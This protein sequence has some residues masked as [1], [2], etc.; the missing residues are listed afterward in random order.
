MNMVVIYNKLYYNKFVTSIIILSLTISLVYLRS[1]N[2][3]HTIYKRR[4][5]KPHIVEKN[6]NSGNA[7]K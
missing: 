6:Q 7:F 3:S 5:K 1:F 2:K 4:N